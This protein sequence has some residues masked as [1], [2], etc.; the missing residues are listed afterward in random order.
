M[1]IPEHPQ[2]ARTLA[3]G[4]PEPATEPEPVFCIECGEKMTGLDDVFDYDGD[5][6]CE[7][8]FRDRI[9]EDMDT[10]DI[11]RKLGFI[12]KPANEFV[13]RNELC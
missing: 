3:T 4:Y 11:A 7:N 8:C 12:V 10:S 6:L 9:M 13:E 2:I 5:T 1:S